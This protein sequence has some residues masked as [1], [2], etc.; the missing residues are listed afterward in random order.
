M[1]RM[2]L[3]EFNTMFGAALKKTSFSKKTALNAV[4]ELLKDET[5]SLLGHNRPEWQP[6]SETTEEIKLR[7]GYALDSPLVRTGDLKYSIEY[8][9]PFRKDEVIIGT[10]LPYAVAQEFG[11]VKIPARPFL[12]LAFFKQEFLVFEMFS[13]MLGSFIDLSNLKPMERMSKLGGIGYK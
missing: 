8:K 3:S 7:E 10:D 11:T 4:G 5:V 2:S 6:L 1:K 13:L 12:W 9:V